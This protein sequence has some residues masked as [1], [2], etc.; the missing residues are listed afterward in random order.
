MIK[1]IRAF[2]TGLLVFV[3]SLPLFSQTYAGR[4]LGSVYDSTGAVVG[5]AVVTITDVQRGISRTLTTD[6]AGEY[7]APN[8][9]PSIYKVRAEAK[10]F[11]SVERPNVQVEVA[12]D[13][14]LDFVLKAGNVSEVV[15]VTEEIPLIETTNATLGGTLSNKTINDLPLNGRNYQN[16]LTLRPGVMIYPGGGGWTQSTNGLRPEDNLY[17]IDGLDNDE[18]F[19]AL[20][21]INGAAIAGDAATILPIDAIQEFNTEE[22][23]P[24]EFGWKPGA[25]VNVGLK[26]GTNHLHGT[27]Y[28]FGRSDSFDA[29]NYFNPGPQAPLNV[30]QFGATVGGAIKKDKF[31]YFLGY[32]GQRYTLGN[33]FVVNV[34]ETIPQTPP[35]TANSFPDASADLLAHGV[36]LSALSLHLAGC[37]LP[38]APAAQIP[39]CTGGLFGSNASNTTNLPNGFPNANRS[40]NGLVKLDYHIND[41][42]ALSGMYFIGDDSL[43]DEDAPYLQPQWSSLAIQRAQTAGA[44]WVRT[45]N[46]RWVNEARFGY[47]HVNVANSV[48]D[49]NVPATHYGINTGV[50]NPVLNGMPQIIVAGFTQLGGSSSW[51]KIEGPNQTFQLIDHVSYLRGKHA[52]KFGGEL[53]HGIVNQASYKKARGQ[54]TFAG[55][56]AFSASTPLEDFLAGEPNVA[57][58][59]IGN[60]QRHLTQWGYAGFIQDDWRIK[61]TIT[62]NLGLRYEY[63][64]PPA[65]ANNLLGNFDPTVSP[66]LGMV[67]VSK[68]ISSPFN[69]DH[70]NFAPRLGIAWDV[71]GK[72]RTV[73]RAGGS[74]IYSTLS[75]NVF[76]AQEDTQNATTLGL[77]AIPTGATIVLPNGTTQPGGGTIAVSSITLNGGPG[78]PLVSGWQNNGPNVPLLP[79]SSVTCGNGVGSNPVPCNILGIDR[80]FR[81]PY[82]GTW[83]VGIQHEFTRDLSLEV[84]YVGNHGARLTGIRDLNQPPL[85]G[86]PGPYSAQFPFLGF[87]N[88]LS[89]LYRSN[90]NGLQ[91]TLTQRIS[92]GLSFT[93]G[94]TYSHALDDSSFNNNQFLPQDSTHPDRE[95]ASGDYDIKHR[96]TLSL[97][98]A[99]PGRKSFAQLLEGWELNSIV[100]LQSGQPWI[101][102]DTADNI[103]GTGE[104]ADRWDFF[105]NPSD[106]T[107]NQNPLPYCTGPLPGDCTQNISNAANPKVFSDQETIAMWNMCSSHPNTTTQFGCYVQGNSVMVAPALGNFGTMGRN[108]FRDSGFRDWDLSV[109]K[110]WKFMERLTAQFRAEFFNVL[111]HPSFANPYGALSGFGPGAT[112]DPSAPGVFGCGCATPDQAGGNPVFGS[113][114][115][116]AIQ[117]GLKLIF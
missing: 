109:T 61:P 51:P 28:A 87:I 36:P 113:G 82:V 84:D 57:N 68:Q 42:N 56:A 17:M 7:V 101:A 93:A 111:N 30:E 25:I 39:T 44:S 67:Q 38:A 6:E 100:T 92:H 76:I 48:L 52:F 117:L 8:L 24:A 13:V 50:T 37:S 103:S 112:A 70:T 43:T 49:N 59:L 96:F 105:G 27:A 58:L 116:R 53:R 114:S 63:T 45:P 88:F 18:P 107:S 40:D 19:S 2:G 9:P 62:L 41:R 85:G 104:F 11:K 15:I 10:G 106:F 23:P 115:N 69:G 16:L 21:V 60:P 71:N 97:T 20:S 65:E 55:G 110:D 31:F 73:L 12:K 26:S 94:Y 90:Y 98:Y 46:S 78:T 102:N 108:I 14:R 54:I 74:I 3:I 77:A 34:P 89:N 81:T 1:T 64:T 99:I 75:M 86:G 47:V 5:G 22:N 32:E 72:G 91:T 83:T 79:A 33:S 29:R 4:I 80:N 35:D 95:Y 66:T